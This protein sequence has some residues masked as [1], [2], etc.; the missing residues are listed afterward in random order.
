MASKR[1][2]RQSRNDSPSNPDRTLQ[3]V[4]VARPQNPEAMALHAASVADVRAKRTPANRAK[5][6]YLMAGSDGKQVKVYST[7]TRLDYFNG[8]ASGLTLKRPPVTQAEG[9]CPGL[10]VEHLPGA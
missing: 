5:P 9:S 4:G 6:W 10:S 3:T 7:L 2:T 1:R 8:K